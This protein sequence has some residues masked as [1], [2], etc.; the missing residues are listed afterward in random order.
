MTDAP[1]PARALRSL[2][3]AI[4]RV[5]P[6][7]VRDSRVLSVV[8]LAA[9]G[10]SAGHVVEI[11]AWLDEASIAVWIAGGWGVDALAGGRTR[12]HRDL[13]L[14]VDRR[15]LDR[16]VG[17]L[18]RCGYRRVRSESVAGALL[19]ERIVCEDPRGRLLDL[20]PVDVQEW[21]RTEVAR[22][23]PDAAAP[24]RAAFAR[25]MLDGTPVPCLSRALQLSAHEGYGH[26]KV[27]DH[28][29]ALLETSD[30]PR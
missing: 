19:P 1:L 23:L 26:R 24:A 12:R 5:T 2:R 3:R 14:L 8:T 20:H 17:V 11:V 28:N 18:G 4:G 15:D 13:D 22:R 30:A 6:R 21:L 10:M 29:V 16:A 27:D 7:R 25:G 9:G